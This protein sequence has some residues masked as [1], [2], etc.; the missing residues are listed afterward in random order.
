ME[1]QQ[2][3]TGS[4]AKV[5]LVTKQAHKEAKRR[6]VE[7]A[8]RRAEAAGV[9]ADEVAQVVEE[10]E[11]EQRAKRREQ[12]A[13]ARSK[14]EERRKQW[15]AATTEGERADGP[16]ATASLTRRQREVVIPFRTGTTG[17]EARV[18]AVRLVRRVWL[19]RHAVTPVEVSVVA[20]DGEEGVFVPTKSSGAVLLAATVT[21]A[22]QGKAPVPAINAQGGRTKLPAKKELGVWIPLSSDL[23][24]LELNGDLVD[25]L[26]DWM[27]TLGDTSTHLDNESEVVVTATDPGDQMQILKLLRAY[28]EVM[29]SKGDCPPVTALDVQHHIDTGDT[30]PIMLKRRLQPQKD[31]ARMV[32]G[33][34]R[35]LSWTMCLVYLDDI[36]IFT[37]GGMQQHLVQLAAVLER[38]SVAGLTLKLKKCV[39]AATLMEYLG[40]ELSTEGV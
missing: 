25:K 21:R 39:F 23:E 2:L 27:A 24:A 31:D 28:R 16:R 4:T 32:N 10:L 9:G 33:V 11:A 37:R 15:S 8:A 20:P 30:K 29:S 1:P 7:G 36:V 5:R 14:L 22:Y 13:Q 17:G 6:R 34:L 19:T 3:K 18:A 38:L 40:H 12:A 35:G 26:D